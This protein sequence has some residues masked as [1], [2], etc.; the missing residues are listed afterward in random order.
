MAVPSGQK[1][2]FPMNQQSPERME[3][4]ARDFQLEVKRGFGD[5]RFL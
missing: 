4:V 1:D 2:S 3:N 5:R